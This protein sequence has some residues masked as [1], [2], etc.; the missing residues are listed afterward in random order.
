MALEVDLPR[1]DANSWAVLNINVEDVTG[2]V[3]VLSMD[4]MIVFRQ[5]RFL[6]KYH[7]IAFWSSVSSPELESPTPPSS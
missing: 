1:V 6:L 2:L 4:E 7:F 5:K 3:V